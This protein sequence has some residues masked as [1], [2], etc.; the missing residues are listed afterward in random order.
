ME[1]ALK[2]LDDFFFYIGASTPGVT[3]EQAELWGRQRPNET[4]SNLSQRIL[5]LNGFCRYLNN[6]GYPSFV[7]QPRKF[8]TTFIP[9]IL[10]HEEMA[11]LFKA[12]DIHSTEEKHCISSS[13]I[14]LFPIALRLLYA[15]AM[16][17]G[18]LVSL[19]VG[20]VDLEE[21]TILIRESKNGKDRL[22]PLSESML[23]V[24]KEY[25]ARHNLFANASMPFFRRR[26][27][28]A[29]NRNTLYSQFR[30]CIEMAGIH[31][32]GRGKGPRLHD[33]RH[34]SAVHSM[35]AMADAG[36][37]LYYC[38]PLLSQYLGHSSL[39]STEKYVRLSEEYFPGVLND[40]NSIA[41]SIF[42]EVSHER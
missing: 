11:K 20:D 32:E 3:R 19:T 31:H 4:D 5:H 12:S 21:G 18:E 13:H 40:V 41:P 35:A 24:L 29:C 15:T 8:H 1:Y 37:D 25:S 33:L 17:A 39:V 14:K 30:I 7:P 2:D 10:S 9:R 42:P 6:V 27:G 23:E 26:D 36:L 22:V 38:L 16:R 34:T 28:K